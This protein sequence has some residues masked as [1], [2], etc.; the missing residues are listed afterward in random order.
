MSGKQAAV[1]RWYLHNLSILMMSE[2]QAAQRVFD[3]LD[4][5]I[6]CVL[7]KDG[8]IYTHGSFDAWPAYCDLVEQQEAEWEAEDSRSK[9]IVEIASPAKNWGASV[10]VEDIPRW[11]YARFVTKGDAL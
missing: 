9:K 7:L 10:H 11:A 3:G 1:Y 6:E 8:R 2:R 5:L 4:E